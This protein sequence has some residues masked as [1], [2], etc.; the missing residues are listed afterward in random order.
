MK[1]ES[2]IVADLLAYESEISYPVTMWGST[3]AAAIKAAG[4]LAPLDPAYDHATLFA[5]DIA[6]VIHAEAGSVITDV[7]GVKVDA[8]LD[9]G[10]L[11]IRFDG[12]VIAIVEVESAMA[13]GVDGLIDQHLVLC[14]AA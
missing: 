13:D 3:Y 9:A 7:T 6:R 12:T 11:L 14:Q 2:D 8:T 1:S 5:R 10:H 4:V